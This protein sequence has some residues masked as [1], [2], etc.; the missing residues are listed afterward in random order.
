MRKDAA[1][2]MQKRQQKAESEWSSEMDIEQPPIQRRRTDVYQPENAMKPESQRRSM[3]PKMSQ[4]LFQDENNPR[5]HGNF[6]AKNSKDSKVS[7]EPKPRNLPIEMT[8]NSLKANN[9]NNRNHFPKIESTST[10]NNPHKI[11]FEYQ[12][13]SQ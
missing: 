1:R 3:A 7:V 5:K 8:D 4:D 10:N 12:Q 9:R 2:K 6:P 13:M 11:Q